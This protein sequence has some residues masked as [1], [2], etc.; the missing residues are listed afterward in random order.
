MSDRTTPTT[1]RRG[2]AGTAPGVGGSPRPVSE[3]PAHTAP[4]KKETAPGH[5][6]PSHAASSDG[7]PHEGAGPTAASAA[8]L[9]ISDRLRFELSPEPPFRWPSVRAPLLFL[10]VVVLVGSLA[11]TGIVS[12]V[13]YEVA[14]VSPQGVGTLLG[15]NISNPAL[16]LLRP[17]QIDWR[18]FSG[19]GGETPYGPVDPLLL[20]TTLH[21]IREYGLYNTTVPLDLVSPSDSGLDPDIYPDAALVQVPRVAHYSNVSAMTLYAL[22]NDSITQPT[23]GF[24]GPSYVNVIVLDQ[25]MFSRGLVPP[26][27]WV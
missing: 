20:N 6:T 4:A 16:F 2:Y 3:P 1:P 15:E 17:S 5:P 19:A 12:A 9:A 14:P 11:Y 21:Y 18:A 8:S 24:V 10:V 7:P 27:T 25:E 23:A 26:G 22:V 13:A